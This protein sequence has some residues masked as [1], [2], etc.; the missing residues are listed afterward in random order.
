MS[1]VRARMA[2]A[3]WLLLGSA[4]TGCPAA[5]EPG[6]PPLRPLLYTEAPGAP[7][8]PPEGFEA[9]SADAPDPVAWPSRHS[10][11]RAAMP[12][13]VADPQPAASP[14]EASLRVLDAMLR[15]DAQALEPLLFDAELLRESARMTAGGAERE[16]T[17]VREESL[18]LLRRMG[19]SAGRDDE[20]VLRPGQVTLGRPRRIDGAVAAEGEEV[21]LHWGNEVTFQHP[22]LGVT[23]TLRIPRLL[24]GTDGSWRLQ[25]P[26]EA[27]WKFTTF[28]ALGLDLPASL[29]DGVHAGWPLAVGNFWHYRTLRPGL[30]EEPGSTMAPMDGFRDEVVEV[31]DHGPWRLVRLMRY[32]DRGA[33]SPERFA[34]IQT[35]TRVFLCARD[36]QRRSADIEWVLAYARHQVPLLVHPL[37]A[38]M[39]WGSAGLPGGGDT[40]RVQ[41]EPVAVETPAGLFQESLEV[42]RTTGR[43]RESRHFVRGVGI[44]SRRT[45]TPG[46]TTVDELLNWRVLQ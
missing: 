35:P 30:D 28:R 32:P 23:F 18:A 42:V 7:L 14:E 44:V 37:E 36:C 26:P 41:P 15:G 3:A 46:L 29:M 11:R 33:R 17:R 25:G 20:A 8:D 27:D 16:A 2:G 21:V 38:G 39:S 9:W 31:V 19:P 6:A 12:Q 22:T 1:L 4:L 34:Y 40:M 13:H 5:E 24:R 45:V 10:T 43:G